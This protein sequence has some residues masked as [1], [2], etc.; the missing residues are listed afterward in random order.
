MKSPNIL[1][2]IVAIAAVGSLVGAIVLGAVGGSFWF[3][4]LLTVPLWLYHI[5]QLPQ[6]SYLAALE[7]AG[8]FLRRLAPYF[9]FYAAQICACIALGRFLRWAFG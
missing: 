4:P 1:L 3:A 6:L 2:S 7:P 8:Q 9:A 5:L